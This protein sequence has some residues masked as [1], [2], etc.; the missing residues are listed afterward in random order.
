MFLAPRFEVLK[1]AS[2]GREMPYSRER[3]RLLNI[4]PEISSYLIQN[5][6]LRTFAGLKR[7][8]IR[9]GITESFEE[10][11]FA[12]TSTIR[13]LC[14]GCGGKP[15]IKLQLKRPVQAIVQC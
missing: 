4:P 15:I 8:M 14:K 2:P 11:P 3:F 13:E 12:V 5:S 10:Q 6:W 7:V 1:R 9:L